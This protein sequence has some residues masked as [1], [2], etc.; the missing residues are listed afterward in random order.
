[1]R[2]LKGTVVSTKMDKTI[3]IAIDTYKS[4]PL[5]KKRY[6]MTQK[7]YAHDEAGVAKE[8]DIVTISETRPL[9][10]TKRWMLMESK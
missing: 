5:Y 7:F 2:T 8:G 9:S 6:K 4:H 10:K 1:M 3:V